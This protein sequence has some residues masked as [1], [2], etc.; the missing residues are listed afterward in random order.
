MPDVR[1]SLVERIAAGEMDAAAELYDRYAAQVY[2]LAR[3]IVRNDGDAEDVVQEVFSQAWRTADRYDSRRGSVIGWLLTITRTRAIDKIRA[4][5]ARP[6][7]EGQV[8]PE[9]LA[10]ADP[11]QPDVLVAAEQASRVRAAL[12]EL[13]APQRTA[14]ELAYYEGLTQSEIAD[15]LS[16]PLGTVKTRMRTALSTL[17]ARLRT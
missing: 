11:P 16:E 4:R 5:Q 3:R 6:D 2:A 1:T 13:P 10:A 14:L 17:R 9:A 7:T 15:R 8:L 12:L